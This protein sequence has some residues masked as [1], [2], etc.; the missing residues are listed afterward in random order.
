MKLFLRLLAIRDVDTDSLDLRHFPF[1]IEVYQDEPSSLFTIEYSYQANLNIFQLSHENIVP[2]S[3]RVTV[4]RVLQRPD[5]DYSLLPTSGLFI[6]FEHVLLD[7]DS[8]IEV[9]YQ[10]EV[11]EGASGG[12]DEPVIV[13]G[14]VGVAP[15][16]AQYY[17]ANAS[18]L[19]AYLALAQGV[20]TEALLTTLITTLVMV[21]LP[22][23]YRRPL[24]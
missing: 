21:A 12:D 13:A 23:R 18:V 1:P 20:V 19:D 24:W 3:E 9:A 6:F 2:G 11:E 5:V 7:E 14:Q 10:Y 8:V 15:G 22:E 16:D 4:D 17:G